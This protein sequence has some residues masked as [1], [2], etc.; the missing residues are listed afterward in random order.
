MTYQF[1]TND[2]AQNY[3]GNNGWTRDA[4]DYWSKPTVRGDN[5]NIPAIA[6]VSIQHNRVDPAY[7]ADYFTVRFI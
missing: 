7:G 3:L 5:A 4:N 1:L 6:I 2:A